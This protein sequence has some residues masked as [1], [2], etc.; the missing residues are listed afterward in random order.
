MQ[1]LSLHILDLV[2]NSVAAD[3]KNIEITIS[4]KDDLLI[5]TISDDGKGMDEETVK[6]VESPFST[7]RTTRKVGLGIPLFKAAA[8]QCEGYFKIQSG[9]NVG[10]TVTGA[11]KI[12]SIDRQP[13]GDLADTIVALVV[14]EKELDFILRLENY[15]NTY[16]F[17]TKEIKEILGDVSPAVPEV[18]NWIA[19]NIKDG[20]STVFG[21][22]LNEV[23]TRIGSDKK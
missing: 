8:E 15:D 10:T 19:D 3:A 16:V 20:V 14:S 11:F 12:Q 1:E 17:D 22:V 13:M 21:G 4:L 7:S 18:M 2:R 9:V 5:I 6:K 23:D